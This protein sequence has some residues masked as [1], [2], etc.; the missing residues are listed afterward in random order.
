MEPRW[1][2]K[3]HTSEPNKV[4]RHVITE[5]LYGTGFQH[6]LI[7]VP[8]RLTVARLLGGSEYS[9]LLRPRL[10]IGPRIPMPAAESR[11]LKRTQTTRKGGKVRSG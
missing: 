10:R 2:R 4:C 9:R 7:V 3:G 1:I 5:A 8:F 6:R 11:A